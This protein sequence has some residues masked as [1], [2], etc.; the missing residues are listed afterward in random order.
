MKGFPKNINTKQDVLNLHPEYPTETKEYLRRLL[1]ERKHWSGGQYVENPNAVLFQ[2]GFTTAEA[3][4]IV[5]DYVEPAEPDP[6]LTPEEQEQKE[7]EAWRQTADCSRLQAKLALDAA[8]LLAT[9]EAF[10]ADPAT[11]TVA[12]L[13]WTEA[14][15]YSR[16]SPLFDVLGPELGMTPEQIDDLFRAA[17]QIEV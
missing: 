9:V 7:L 12:K 1:D 6:P 15:R 5:T 14:Y 8:G 3:L 4:T 10:I 13:A 11:P 16:K 17:Q 2:L